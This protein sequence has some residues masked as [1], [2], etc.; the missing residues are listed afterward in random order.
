MSGNSPVQNVVVPET[1][2]GEIAIAPPNV[3]ISEEKAGAIKIV[4]P[5]FLELWGVVF[6]SCAGGW[7][8]LA[9]SGIL[10][11][12]FCNLPAAPNLSGMTSDQAKD[13]LNIYNQHY[14]KW[15]D[16]LIQIF[17]LLVT[18]TV[19]PLTTL[20]LGYLFGKGKS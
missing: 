18:K 13:A 8:L 16:S 9:S 19:L 12:F 4:P 5:S 20:L 10:I 3:V 2:A 11:Y 17:D 6:V 1:N 7:I 15:R 14:D